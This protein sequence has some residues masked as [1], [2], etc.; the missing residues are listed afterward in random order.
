MECSQCS[1]SRPFVTISLRFFRLLSA[2]HSSEERLENNISYI[3]MANH[4]S[5]LT[6]VR[7]KIEAL[8]L[9]MSKEMKNVF[10]GP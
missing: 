10:R 4:R 7:W 8:A 3:E 5:R 9:K 1:P 6:V 2:D